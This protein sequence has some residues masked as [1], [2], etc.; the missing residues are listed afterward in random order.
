MTKEVR[1]PQ[2][3]GSDFFEAYDL[4]EQYLL[5][6]DSHGP[7]SFLGKFYRLQAKEKQ[8]EMVAM[9]EVV[10]KDSGQFALTF[11]QLVANIQQTRPHTSDIEVMYDLLDKGMTEIEGKMVF[12]DVIVM[13]MLAMVG[14]LGVKIEE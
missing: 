12:E 14:G 8:A 3:N 11:A 4:V 1:Q 13:G 10:I 9:I 5:G 2:P 7:H 6:V